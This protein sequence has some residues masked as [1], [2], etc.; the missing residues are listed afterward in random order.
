MNTTVMR[1]QI[2]GL[3]DQETAQLHN[4]HIFIFVSIPQTW[5]N[6]KGDLKCLSAVIILIPGVY[7]K[8]T[9]HKDSQEMLQVLLFK[10]PG[11]CGQI[12]RPFMHVLA[13]R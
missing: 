8:A 6:L 1:N 5:L 4:S 3:A 13:S 2:H 11:S 7:I 10:N 12:W 9:D